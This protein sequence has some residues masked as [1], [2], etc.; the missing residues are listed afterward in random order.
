MK[1]PYE[2]LI[3]FD[4]KTGDFKGAHL[5]Q[6]ENGQ[7]LAPEAIKAEDWP[8]IVSS[9]NTAAL[10]RVTE[11]EASLQS[12]QTAHTAALKAEKDAATAALKVEKDAAK[13]I[14]DEVKANLQAL[15][16]ERDQLLA[17]T[18]PE[19]LKAARAARKALVD[20]LS[21]A[22]EEIVNLSK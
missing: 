13:Q 10:N 15:K 4:H 11:L 12:L 17:T 3:R 20:K 22:D 1:K 19:R 6:M 18:K 8:S 5:A 2:I 14:I 21:L 16:G 9:V 7:Q